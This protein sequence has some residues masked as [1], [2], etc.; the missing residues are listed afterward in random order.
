MRWTEEQYNDFL[1]QASLEQIGKKHGLTVA[2]PEESFEQRALVR[3]LDMKGILFCHVPNG[4][5]RNIGVAKKLKAEGCRPGV[6]DI[7]I[8][9]PPPSGGIGVAIELKRK[10][11]GNVSDYQ[12]DW[13]KS[14][15]LR[16]WQTKVCK[17]ADDAIAWLTGLG[18]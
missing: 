11:G 7:L 6:P 12:K 14:L 17:G 15:N 5:K 18:Y 2:N 4:G 3:W 16:G 10:K 13:L 1:S 8:F 9:D